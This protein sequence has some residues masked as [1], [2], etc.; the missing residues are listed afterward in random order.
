LRLT[1][2]ECLLH[3]CIL[4][5]SL[6]ERFAIPGCASLRELF[7]IPSCTKNTGRAAQGGFG[8]TKNAHHAA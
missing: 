6:R 3:R 2:V 8:C 7:A 5:L 4:A 1:G